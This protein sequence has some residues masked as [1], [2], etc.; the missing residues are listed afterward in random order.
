MKI[1]DW[2]Q[3]KLK[4]GRHDESNKKI[5]SSKSVHNQKTVQEPAAGE[6]EVNDWLYGLL[7]IGT[8]GKNDLKENPELRSNIFPEN[9]DELDQD[10]SL[11][12]EVENLDNEFN[13]VESSPSSEQQ[14]HQQE[15]F[16][17]RQ[18]SLE[19]ERSNNISDESN[20]NKRASLQRSTSL[21]ISRG[22]NNKDANC[23][24]K[25]KNSIAKKSF[26]F[27]LKKI[28]ACGSGFPVPPPPQLVPEPRMEKILRAIIH[29][30]IYPQSSSPSL[31]A[32]KYLEN[33]HNFNDDITEKA[34]EG[35]SKWVKTDSEYIVL[36]I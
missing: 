23:V 34:H 30:K 16:L 22:N 17:G 25:S 24:D 2:M 28:F 35:S 12:E 8:F 29:K 13:S 26:S 27:L 18:T 14:L 20:N 19:A 5:I 7:A 11:Y 3:T 32:K 36:E 1:F 4:Y 31:S 9:A 10:H 33:K 21:V 15:K 6:E